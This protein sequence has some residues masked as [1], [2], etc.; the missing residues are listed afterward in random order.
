MPHTNS[1][2][3]ELRMPMPVA[4]TLAR[5]RAQDA[6][7]EVLARLRAATQGLHK[8]ATDATRQHFENMLSGQPGMRICALARALE[9][10]PSRLGREFVLGP[11]LDGESPRAK[12]DPRLA[13]AQVVSDAAQ[14]NSTVARAFADGVVDAHEGRQIRAYLMQLVRDAGDVEVDK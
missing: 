11:L 10:V 6:E 13:M 9:V 5:Q 3:R 7:R 12:K 1:Q 2:P 14:V 4:A 8:V